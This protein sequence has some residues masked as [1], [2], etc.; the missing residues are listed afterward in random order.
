MPSGLS[1]VAHTHTVQRHARCSPLAWVETNVRVAV[2]S[3]VHV[4][5]ALRRRPREVVR[6]YAA[7][8]G[9]AMGDELLGDGQRGTHQP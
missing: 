6:A 5:L 3:D 1:T 4:M 9:T 2:G 8:E 7:L